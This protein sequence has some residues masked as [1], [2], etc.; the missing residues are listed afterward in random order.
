MW[1]KNLA[2]GTNGPVITQIG[3]DGGMLD[4]PVKIDPNTGAKLFMAPAERADIIIDFSQVASG[5][6]LTLMNDAVAPYPSGDSVVVG[7]TDRI[8][9]FVVNGQMISSSDQTK[10]GT[11]K[12]LVPNSLKSSPNVKLTDFAGNLKTTPDKIRQL[13]LNEIEG[14]GGPLIVILN[15]SR[16]NSMAGPGQFSKVT[17]LPVEGTTE[18]WQIINTTEDAHPIHLHLIQFQVVGHQ[19]YDLDGYVNTYQS[20]FAN[21]YTGGE[22]PPFAYD[23]KNADGAVGGNP[24]VGPYLQGSVIPVVANERGWK[25]TYK[26]LPHEV[27]TFIVRFAPV[28]FPLT[29]PAKSLLFPFDPSK[30]PGYVWH[31]HILDHEDNEMMRKYYMMPSPYRTKSAEL[32]AQEES[33]TVPLEGYS[34]EQ[35]FPNPFGVETN[36]QFRIPDNMHV[37][38]KLFNIAGQEI[39]TL[40]DAEAPA[41]LNTVI[42]SADNLK[43]GVYFYKLKAGKFSATK[44]LIIAK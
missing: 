39:S 36:I 6:V 20:S 23:V 19:A 1:L 8:M 30:G 15:N 37:Q 31:C 25:D 17:E 10:T 21:P 22:G 3:T 11:D 40:I 26:V 13:T 2:K 42:L 43:E 9:Q 28:T 4:S 32:L 7:T 27:T 16:Y 5:T 38:L 34:L 44:K 29:T 18:L 35:N 41:G 12:S 14:P 24:A 33:Q